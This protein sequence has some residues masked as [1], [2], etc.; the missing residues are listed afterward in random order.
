MSD[1]MSTGIPAPFTL[2]RKTSCWRKIVYYPHGKLCRKGWPTFGDRAAP[3]H[4]NG[5][6]GEKP[7]GKAKFYGILSY[8]ISR[9]ESR[10]NPESSTLH[11]NHRPAVDW[12]LHGRFRLALKG[13]RPLRAADPIESSQ[14]AWRRYSSEQNCLCYRGVFAS[15]CRLSGE[16]LQV[17]ISC[18]PRFLFSHSENPAQTAKF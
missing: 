12:I 11:P 16:A 10:S 4:S 15:G 18:P 8:F 7:K 17:C 5:R 9:S 13:H 1:I 6:S 14:G 3:L 2:G